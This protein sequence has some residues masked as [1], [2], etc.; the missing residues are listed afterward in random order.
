MKKLFA[1][2]LITI[3]SLTA[4]EGPEGPQG[5]PGIN[6]L[7]QV[8]EVT[9]NLNSSNNFQ[10]IVTI[11]SSIE[12]YESDVILVYRWEGSFNGDDIWTPLPVTYFTEDGGTFLYAFNHTFYDLEFFLDANFDQTVLGPEWTNDQ[13]FRIAIV[14]AEFA[15]ANLTMEQLEN[16]A[17]VEFIGN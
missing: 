3:L 6:I 10:R 15:D 9:I 12:V 14:P 1:L 11:P 16:S 5:P 8:F 17:Q 7:G 4:C 2:S 13:S